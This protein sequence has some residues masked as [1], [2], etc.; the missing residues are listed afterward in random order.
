[1]PLPT[2]SAEPASSVTAPPT[3]SAPVPSAP[4][5]PSTRPPAASDSP[6]LKAAGPTDHAVERQ[7][8]VAGQVEDAARPQ[9]DRVG[10]RKRARGA[11]QRHVAADAERTAAQ[12][13]RVAQQQATGVERHAA[14]EV[15]D[16]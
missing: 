15:V 2:L 11:I 1:M 10:E 12:R 7:R 13:S 5:L 3:F 14:T 9:I 4:A 8:L 16:A 6:P